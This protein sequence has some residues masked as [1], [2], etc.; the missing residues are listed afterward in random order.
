LTVFD[1]GT[2]PLASSLNYRVGTTRPNETIAKL[3][4]DGALCIFTLSS[5]HVIVD[6]AGYTLD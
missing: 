3:S 1:C 5:A 2:R 6:L 4:P